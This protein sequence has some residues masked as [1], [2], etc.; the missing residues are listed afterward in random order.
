MIK[1]MGK[2][3]ILILMEQSTLASGK[4]TNK[5]DLVYRSGLMDKNMKD[6]TKMVQRQAK[7]CLNFLMV[8]IMKVNSSITRSMGKVL[9]LL[10]RCLRL[11]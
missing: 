6:S 1:Q 7:V 9:V 11:V 2:V 8:V 5:M 10:L 4:M 3:L